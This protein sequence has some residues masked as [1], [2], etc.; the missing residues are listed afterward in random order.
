MAVLVHAVGR[1]FRQSDGTVLRL[2][3]LGGGVYLAATT[4]MDL[5]NNGLPTGEDNPM[6]FAW[7]LALQGGVAL[8]LL[9]LMPPTRTE[10]ADLP[11]ADVAA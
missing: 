2:L 11:Y 9:G 4:G 1:Y 5:R 7:P 3:L 6:A 10:D 8:A